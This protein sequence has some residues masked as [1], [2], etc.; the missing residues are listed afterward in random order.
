MM[1]AL[2]KTYTIRV[3]I[4]EGN[5]EFWED[6]RGK[7]GA[8]LVVTEVKRCLAEHGFAEP[9]CQVSLDKFEHRP[10]GNP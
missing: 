6:L 5:D 7:T 10:P 3:T 8:D 9:E 1:I 2:K 4:Q